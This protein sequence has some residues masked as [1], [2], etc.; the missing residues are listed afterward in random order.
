MDN[1]RNLELLEN[2]Y[3]KLQRL[4]NKKFFLANCRES[5]LLPRGLQ[6]NFN[7][8]FGVNEYSL[9]NEI[10]NILEKASSS[11]LDSLITSCEEKEKVVEEQ[12]ESV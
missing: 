1:H 9:V 2:L 11:I 3:D 10:E 12:F 6:L 5:G 7:L 4:K 8:A